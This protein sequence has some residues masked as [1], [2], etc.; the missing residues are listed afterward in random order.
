MGKRF[1]EEIKL[2][3]W[4]CGKGYHQTLKKVFDSSKACQEWFQTIH[5]VTQK[6]FPF[7]NTG[8]FE[9]YRGLKSQA[10]QLTGVSVK[11]VPLPDTVLGA[12]LPQEK[13]GAI[14]INSL[15]HPVFKLST[16]AHELSHVAVYEY[17]Q[18]SHDYFESFRIR[19]RL[20]LFME[21]LRDKEEVFAD[22][23]I[24]IGTYPRMDFE[25]TFSRMPALSLT[26]LVKAVKH[27]K[28][29]YPDVM[30]GFLFSRAVFLNMAFIVHFLR[31]RIFLYKE[32][33]I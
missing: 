23:L 10:E 6:Y 12:Y 2:L 18:K 20:T 5:H 9:N 15:V 16:L 7:F 26:S 24:A 29:H 22:A 30:R 31:L 4:I 11:E 28:K 1:F 32:L 21:T 25:K 14:L 17:Y 33:N 13:S 3:F 27:L 19:N 8:Y